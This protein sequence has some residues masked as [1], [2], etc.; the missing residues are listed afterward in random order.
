MWVLRVRETNLADYSTF[1]QADDAGFPPQALV[2]EDYERCEAEADR[3]RETRFPGC[4]RAVGR[5][6]G[7]VNLA[8]FGRRLMVPW[9]YPR[10]R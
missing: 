10:R 4:A 6:A 7:A 8:L 9:D 1:E 2:G 5:A 3:L